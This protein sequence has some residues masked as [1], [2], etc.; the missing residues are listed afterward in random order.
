MLNYFFKLLKNV[1]WY[2][3]FPTRIW[4]FALTFLTSNCVCRNDAE[5]VF[6]RLTST[7]PQDANPNAYVSLLFSHLK[8]GAPFPHSGYT[9]VSSHRESWQGGLGLAPNWPF[10]RSCPPWSDMS[11]KVAARGALRKPSTR[12][13]WAVCFAI[14]P[15]SQ[16]STPSLTSHPSSH[17]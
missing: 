7:L 15:S 12:S 4:G 1:I 16:L 6:S 9:P 14:H 11:H 10:H 2:E 13:G 8:R 17:S 3:I 5:D